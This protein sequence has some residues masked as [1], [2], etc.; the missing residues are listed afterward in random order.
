M[1][2]LVAI[3]VA[4]LFCVSGLSIAGR[5]A[6]AQDQ[7][8]SQEKIYKP[9]EVTVRAKIKHR[10]DPRYTDQARRHRTSGTV[11]VRMVLRASGEVTDIV[12]LKGLPNGLNDS[13]VRAAQEIRF[14]PAIKDDRE[15]SQYLLLEY[16]FRIY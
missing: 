13:A 2:Y 6:A 12:V 4:V 7:R 11:T 16:G 10:P 15:V 9:A 14:E 5:Q 8:Q 1:K 3:T